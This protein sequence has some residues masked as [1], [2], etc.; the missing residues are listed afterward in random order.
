MP[1]RIKRRP[2]RKSGRRSGAC[3]CGLIRQS[4]HRD[5]VIPL[6]KGGPDDESNFQYLCANCHEDKTFGEHQ[7]AEF[8]EWVRSRV[9]PERREALRV[10]HTGRHVS[11]ET[12]AKLRAAHPKGGKRPDVSARQKAHWADPEWRSKTMASIAKRKMPRK[13]DSA[14]SKIIDAVHD[15]TAPVSPKDVAKRTGIKRSIVCAVL[16]VA[17]TE[18][19]VQRAGRGLYVW[20]TPPEAVAPS[21]DFG[22]VLL[23]RTS[24]N[25]QTQLSLALGSGLSR[26]IVYVSPAGFRDRTGHRLAL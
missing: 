4:L 19:R 6:W 23:V 26:P 11:A 2:K 25:E 22:P 9:T 3:R 21:V 14:T 1:E 20:P 13:A 24:A 16:S 17:A 12:R 7:S 5:H 10:L 15:A 8:R 18:G